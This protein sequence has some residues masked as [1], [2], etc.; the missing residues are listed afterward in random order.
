MICLWYYLGVDVS[1][2]GVEND[3]LLQVAKVPLMWIGYCINNGQ[4]VNHFWLSLIH[5]SWHQ[6]MEILVGMNGLCWKMI[7]LSMGPALQ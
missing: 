2:S 1:A 5:V 6:T 4:Q 7:V 3:K